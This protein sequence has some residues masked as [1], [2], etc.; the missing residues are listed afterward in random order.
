M[1]QSQLFSPDALGRRTPSSDRLQVCVSEN[2]QISDDAESDYE[3]TPIQGNKHKNTPIRGTRDTPIRGTRNTPIRGTNN[4]GTPIQGTNEEPRSDEG[5]GREWRNERV[6][7]SKSESRKRKREK[8]SGSESEESSSDDTSSSNDSESDSDSDIFN[9]SHVLKMKGGE[10]LPK[11]ITKYIEKYANNGITKATRQE[12]TKNCKTPNT[13][14]LKSKETDRFIKKLSRKRFNQAMSN[15]KEKIIINTQNRILD[16]TGPLA[17]L[18]HEAEKRALVLIGNAHYVY[19]TDRRKTLLS[20]LV[21]ECVDLIEDSSGRKALRNSKDKLFGNTFR[22]LLAKDS[23]DNREIS[24]LLPQRKR[25]KSDNKNSY[26]YDNNNERRNSF[27]NG[28]GRPQQFFRTGPSNNRYQFG[29]HN[30]RG[31]Q[32]QRGRGSAKFPLSRKTENQ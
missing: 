22:K 6:N 24:D 4:A 27:R 11:K 17:I 8:E 14:R 26:F 5:S 15:K 31:Q 12:I 3:Q 23:K 29:G 7:A 28:A 16:A 25:F 9:P 2:E 10:K 19:L 21:P 30:Y 18:W 20:K 32:S 1:A 13:K